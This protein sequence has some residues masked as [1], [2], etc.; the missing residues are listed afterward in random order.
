[1]TLGCL[2]FAG[3]HGQEK[4]QAQCIDAG[5]QVVSDRCDETR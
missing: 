5:P 4:Q 3:Q 2:I 1:M